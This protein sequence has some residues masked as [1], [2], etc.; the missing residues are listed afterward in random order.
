MMLFLVLFFFT[1]N[2]KADIRCKYVNLPEGSR[3]EFLL[4][5]KEKTYSLERIYSHPRKGT[6][7]EIL[8]SD[9][10]CVMAKS[11]S[12]V[13][14]CIQKGAENSEKVESSLTILRQE[15]L[16]PG[17]VM[18]DSPEPRD[19]INITY[20]LYFRN[21]SQNI[22]IKKNFLNNQCLSN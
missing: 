22:E 12:A 8:A 17:P 11:D 16:S 13:A 19:S 1:F 14:S 18:R 3:E 7:Q 4:L 2:A 5:K 15:I 9:L 6:K 20:K 10:T 21:D